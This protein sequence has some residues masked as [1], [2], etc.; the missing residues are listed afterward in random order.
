MGGNEVWS[1]SRV[2]DLKV[3]GKQSWIYNQG[4][5]LKG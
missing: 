4:S 2:H 1:T 3:R 5:S